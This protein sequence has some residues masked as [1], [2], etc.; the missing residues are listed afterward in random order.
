MAIAR[1]NTWAQRSEMIRTALSQA[2]AERQ[3][4]P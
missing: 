2:L 4:V 3:R 1:A